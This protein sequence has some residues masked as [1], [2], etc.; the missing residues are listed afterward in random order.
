MARPLLAINTSA[1]NVDYY[2]AYIYE[3]IGIG[4]LFPYITKSEKFLLRLKLLI[5]R[6]V[7]IFD[8]PLI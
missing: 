5:A 4:S 1:G 6:P 2:T 8:I 7:Q 3:R